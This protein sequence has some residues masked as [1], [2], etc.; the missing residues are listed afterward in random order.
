MV[1]ALSPTRPGEHFA[2]SVAVQATTSSV[3]GDAYLLLY[4]YKQQDG[5]SVIRINAAGATTGRFRCL[6]P[7]RQP[8]GAVYKIAVHGRLLFLAT[9]EG[10]VSVYGLGQ[11]QKMT[12]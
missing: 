9:T 7:A 2:Q 5:P 8:M 1:D 6:P 12:Q 10:H 3:S 11:D 4:P